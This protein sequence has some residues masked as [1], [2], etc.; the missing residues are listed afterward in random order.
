MKTLSPLLVASLCVGACFLVSV[1]ADA[2]SNQ[3]E[4]INTN[5]VPVVIAQQSQLDL[6]PAFGLG[7]GFGL[8]VFGFGWILRMAKN[9]GR[10]DNG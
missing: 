6:Y 9:V 8:T 2:Q 10:P 4:I 1:A 3:V 5:P 7:F